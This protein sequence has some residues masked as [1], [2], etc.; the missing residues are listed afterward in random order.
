MSVLQGDKLPIIPEVVIQKMRDV[1]K[2]ARDLGEFSDITK[3]Q[4]SAP[5]HC[6]VQVLPEW[7]SLK[8]KN[9]ILFKM[10]KVFVVIPQIHLKWSS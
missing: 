2:K 5:V 7:W 8:D 3:T 4:K 6:Y 10:N 9:M 1:R